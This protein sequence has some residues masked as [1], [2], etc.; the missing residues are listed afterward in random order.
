MTLDLAYPQ[1]P[2][3]LCFHSEPRLSEHHIYGPCL[4]IVHLFFRFSLLK[5]FNSSHNSQH[6]KLFFSLLHL[7]VQRKDCKISKKKPQNRLRYALLETAYHESETQILLI[8]YF[9]DILTSQVPYILWTVVELI[10][11]YY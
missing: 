6:S 4:I 7:F 11:R 2:R 8:A 1:N 3:S 9:S 5:G 10:F